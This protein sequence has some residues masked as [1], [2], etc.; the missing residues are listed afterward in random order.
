[1]TYDEIIEILND[2]MTTVHSKER[3]QLTNKAMMAIRELS[4][5]DGLDLYG[6]ALNTLVHEKSLPK[7]K[8]L[9]VDYKNN[10]GFETQ[11]EMMRKVGVEFAS[12]EAHADLRGKAVKVARAMADKKELKEEVEFCLVLPTVKSED[13]ANSIVELLK[14]K[15]IESYYFAR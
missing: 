15:G 2:A 1:M 13:E 12:P 6:E 14:E 5:K 4:L 11:E 8:Q 7:I 10:V 3:K 9:V